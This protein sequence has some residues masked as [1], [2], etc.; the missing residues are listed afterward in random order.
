MGEE[1]GTKPWHLIH[2]W[3]STL[4]KE[5][6]R[7]LREI[8]EKR[9]KWTWTHRVWVTT[10]ALNQHTPYCYDIYTVCSMRCH[11]QMQIELSDPTHCTQQ[12]IM[13]EIILPC[14]ETTQLGIL[15]MYAWWTSPHTCTYDL[16]RDYKVLTLYLLEYVLWTI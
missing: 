13:L 9:K 10:T 4:E 5:E 16:R 1:V 12:S 6:E 3:R 11:L 14:Q 15:G 8:E 7:G 2:I